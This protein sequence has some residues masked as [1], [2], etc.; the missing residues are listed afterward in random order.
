MREKK[1]FQID[2][3]KRLFLLTLPFIIATFLFCYLPLLGWS[4][5]FFDYRPGL[6]LSDCL[7]VGFDNITSL[8]VNPFVRSEIIRVLRNTFAMSF[9]GLVTA[10]LPLL[11]AVFLTEIKAKWHRKMVQTLTTI[12]NFLSWV[13]VYSIVWSMLS[14]N[15]G[16]VNRVL[17]SL[18]VIQEGISFL[19]LTNNVWLTMLAYSLWKNLGWGAIIYI[20]S[21]SSIDSKLYEAAEIDGAGRF[22][23]MW[24]ISIP[25]L[26]PTFFVLMILSIGNFLN[27]GIDQYFVFQNPMN[28]EYIEVLDLYVYNGGFTAGTISLSTAIGMLK[29][30]VSVVLL[31]TANRASKIIRKESIF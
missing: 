30:I 4:Y 6:K 10:P 29:T 2:K 13:M 15:D 31:F 3:G 28:K 11:F 24:H 17:I 12:P 27:N 18:G 1:I 19:T 8:I 26:M 21:L 16:F 7:F 20:A 14:V 22:Q 9:L 5:V 23:K 25:G